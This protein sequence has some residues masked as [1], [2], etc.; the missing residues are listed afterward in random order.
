[1]R[2]KLF[3]AIIFSTLSSFATHN[4][5][6]YISY[7]AVKDSNGNYIPGRYHFIIYTYTNP[8]S[9][10]ADRDSETILFTNLGSG[11]S[12]TLLCQRTNTTISIDLEGATIISQYGQLANSP[13]NYPGLP[14]QGQMLVYPYPAGNI[15][16]TYGGVKVNTYEGN[17]NFNNA[18]G[19]YVF[20]MIDPNLDAAIQNLT[21]AS[22][23][24]A[25]A[26]L[27]TLRLG[28]Y[29]NYNNTPIATNPPIDN[30]CAGQPFYYNPGMGL[31]D[32]DGD[33]IAY[34]LIPFKTG[35]TG[36]PPTFPNASGYIPQTN[37]N[38]DATGTLTWTN[39]PSGA[40]GEYEVDMFI[41]EYRHYGGHM[42]EMGSMIFAVQ[43]YVNPCTSVV[44]ITNASGTKGCIEAGS[45]YTSPNITASETPNASGTLSLTATGV[46]LTAPNTAVF[47]SIPGN[48]SVSGHLSWTPDCNNIQLNPY[49]IT[50]QATDGASPPDANYSNISVQVVSPPVS[51]FSTSVVGNDSI[52]LSWSPPA[53]IGTNTTNVIVGYL[54]YRA[55]DCVSYSVSPCKT[56]VPPIPNGVASSSWYLPIGT[57][58]STVFYDTNNG[59]GLPAGNSYSYIVIAQYADG[60][61]S[62]APPYSSTTT[63]VTLHLGVPILTNVSVDTTDASVGSMFVR[64]Q[65]PLTFSP[66]LDT[67]KYPGPYHFILQHKKVF[68]GS[69]A[70]T[71]TTIYTSPTR[72]YFSQINT[73]ADT[74]FT[75]NLIN[76]QDSQYSYKVLFYADTNHF[77]GSADP[78]SSIFASGVGHDKRVAL[79]WTSNTPWQDTL[80]YIYMQATP[81]TGYTLVG[82]TKLTVDTIKGLTNKHTYCFKIMSLGSYFNSHI[83][84]PDTNWS[85]KVCV[86][87][88]DDSPPCQPQ[89]SV[90]GNCNESINKLTWRN[91]DHA[92]NIDDVLKYYIYYTPRQDSTFALIDSVLNVNDTTYTTNYNLATIAGC[93]VIVA[94]DSAG[95]RSAWKD[96]TCT[97]DCPEYE[98]P[99]IF[100]PNGDNINDLYIP[101]K[102]KYVRS[103]NFVMYNRWGE[104]VYENTSPALGWDGKSKQMKQFV[105][106]GTYFY[107]CTVNEIHYY[108]IESIKLKGFVQVLK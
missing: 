38:V 48:T 30:A 80:Y 83:T 22:N 43:I 15:P 4:R 3:V 104:V 106:D 72:T 70:G 53:C 58:T 41:R 19:T 1:M 97:D 7:T 85:Q 64:W 33:S 78:A 25:F 84:S 98:L 57:C 105:P 12:D 68:P 91:P 61:L 18:N 35:V 95:N 56:G 75:D 28:N 107:T 93:Y 94:V 17:W 77:V 74:T 23:G 100:T 50:V 36:N 2:V 102:N 65:K 49:F 9:Y 99:N 21:G 55:S 59:L 46:P 79:S 92:C 26:L 14:G 81:N 67:V 11:V 6:G 39:V 37:L 96:T 86:K 69:N 24:V 71:Y 52:K 32:M 103:V 63:C 66:N 42:V 44:G 60:S 108:G 5:A 34:S 29:T 76:T 27:D 90:A 54:I 40:Q 82:S 13:Y 62:V 51:N 31:Y 20:G 101:V 87:P 16:P 88:I 45:A 10:Q 73:L 8:Y 89:L 47:S